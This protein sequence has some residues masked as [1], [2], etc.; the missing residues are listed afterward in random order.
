SAVSRSG[1]HPPSGLFTATGEFVET[2]THQPKLLVKMTGG[3]QG[4]TLAAGESKFAVKAEPLFHSIEEKP[5]IGLAQA[6]QWHI[7]TA[8]EE[9][10]EVNVWD[11]CHQATTG[12]FGMAGGG[13]V[14][15]AEPDIQQRWV[16][17]TEAQS[18]L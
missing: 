10:D 17:G 6:P 8:E 15:F 7:V 2:L 16:F 18:L 3:Q 5:A 14:E 1:N 9:T 4:L 13:R 11:L 12:E